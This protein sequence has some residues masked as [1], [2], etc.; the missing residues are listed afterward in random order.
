MKLIVGLG[1]PGAEYA[2]TRHNVGFWVVESLARKWSGG[3]FKK[4]F[5]SLL[6]EGKIGDEPV[7]FC[8][9]QTYMNLSGRAVSSVMRYWKISLSDLAVIH[10]E[11]DLPVGNLKVLREGRPAGHRGVASLQQELASQ[12]FCRFRV[13]I[14]SAERKGET[15]DFVL[16]EFSKEEKAQLLPVLQRTEEGLETWI[17][18]G[19]EAAIRFC[20]QPWSSL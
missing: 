11:L 16:G 10:D 15:A 13:G 20:H 9:P 14:H 1:N 8:L 2:H 5:D 12:S 19:V 4:K 7:L 18:Q 3:G 6:C 17:Q